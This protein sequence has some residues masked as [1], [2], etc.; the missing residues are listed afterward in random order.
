MKWQIWQPRLAFGLPLLE[1]KCLR[2]ASYQLPYI[3]KLCMEEWQETWNSTPANKL[4]CETIA[5]KK[6]TMYIA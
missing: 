2:T 3:S 1:T 6:Q 4:Q 5:G